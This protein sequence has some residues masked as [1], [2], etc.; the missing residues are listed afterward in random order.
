MMN[1]HKETVRQTNA[2]LNQ[3]VEPLDRDVDNHND[4]LALRDEF[5]RMPKIPTLMHVDDAP[6]QQEPGRYYNW[7]LTSEQSGGSIALHIL[8]IEPGFSADRH[9]HTDEEEFWFVLEGELEITVGDETQICGPGS[10]AYVPPYGTHAFRALNE[11]C[12]ILHWNSPGGHERLAP[13]IQRLKHLG[14]TTR[15]DARESMEA[16]EYFFHNEQ[17]FIDREAALKKID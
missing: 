1:S 8:N 17:V 15:D 4:Y 5:R 10:F 13:G 11:T 9:H 2:R 3:P 16:H 12:R 7:L 6:I 14:K